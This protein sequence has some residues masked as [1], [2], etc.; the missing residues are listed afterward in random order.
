MK[1]QIHSLEETWEHP[2]TAGSSQ[3]PS[4]EERLLL[5]GLGLPQ[6]VREMGLGH[7]YLLQNHLSKTGSRAIPPEIVEILDSRGYDWRREPTLQRIDPLNALYLDAIVRLNEI[8][9]HLETLYAPH[10]EN[11]IEMEH[12]AQVLRGANGA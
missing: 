12:I 4:D 11:A 5:S 6:N 10:R 9:T 7:V 3:H 1:T 2:S 8:S